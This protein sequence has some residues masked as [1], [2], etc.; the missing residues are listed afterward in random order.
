MRSDP[1]SLVF[2]WS[3]HSDTGGQSRHHRPPLSLSTQQV[4]SNH[5]PTLRST[6]TLPH[7]DTRSDHIDNDEEDDINDDE[8]TRQ[9]G[10][11][12]ASMI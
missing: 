3:Q 11:V 4:T 10:L 5:T 7:R 6:G 8:D 1:V 12:G 9:S 2:S